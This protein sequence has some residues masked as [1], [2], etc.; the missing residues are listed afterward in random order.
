MYYKIVCV[1][2]FTSRIMFMDHKVLLQISL[3]LL[4]EAQNF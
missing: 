4:Y 2:I 3:V 1:V